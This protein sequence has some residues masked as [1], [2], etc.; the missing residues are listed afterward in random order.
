LTGIKPLYEQLRPLKIEDIVGNSQVKKILKNWVNAKRP[1]SFII[2]GPPGSGK[3]SIISALTK[4]L[5]RDYSIF[6]FSGALEGTKKIKEI[7]ST[8]ENLFSKQKILFV[9]EVHRLNRAEQDTL[10]LG[11]EKGE[12]ILFGATTEN[13]AVTIN[14]ALLSR[15]LVFK[16]I[17]LKDE[18]YED[19][20]LRT[21]NFF[22]PKI[23]IS[24][25]ARKVMIQYSNGDLRRII[26]I[27][28]S[29]AQNNTD[30][31]DTSDLR[32]IVDINTSYNEDDK[33]NFIS[34][35]IKSMRA[36]DP[37]AALLYLSYMLE[38]GEDPMYIARRMVLL[39]CE[40]IGLADPQAITVAVSAMTATQNIGYPECY[41]P[42]AHATLYLSSMPKSNSVN[43]AYVNAREF[44]QNNPVHVPPKLINAV[45]KL[46][47]KQGY[48]VQYKYPHSYNGFIKESC[49]PQGLENKIFFS[50][51]EIGFEKKIKERLELLWDGLKKYTD[52]RKDT[53]SPL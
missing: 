36:S 31:I 43:T 44:M 19:F 24:Q 27:I 35:Y 13:P 5:E 10:L 2:W 18:E 4:E 38:N 17:L 50:P 1:R 8:G 25:E 40:D 53:N 22:N 6:S 33:Y 16:T 47:E 46:M 12:I 30:N 20:F 37:D 34:A 29:L 51:K 15:L 26:N 49:M 14:P 11:I 9:D 21:E 28:E 41:L 23:K 45:N 3:S 7:L 32:S 42:L 48:G 39:S 52:S